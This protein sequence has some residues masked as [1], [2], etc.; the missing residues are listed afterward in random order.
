MSFT[1]VAGR[2]F[3]I[4]HLVKELGEH[5]FR[6]TFLQV[7]RLGSVAA[8]S[9]GGSRGELAAELTTKLLAGYSGSLRPLEAL[10]ADFILAQGSRR[11][12]LHEQCVYLLLAL[13]TLYCG[14]VG[15]APS[16]AKVAFW[17]LAANDYLPSW[18]ADAR[19]LD[20][21]EDAVAEFWRAT[22]FNQ[23]N[24]SKRDLVRGALL[25]RERPP[26]GPLGARWEKLQIEAFGMPYDQYAAELAAP[27]S[28]LA[29]TWGTRLDN[30]PLR[31]P[32]IEPIQWCRGS[33]AHARFFSTRAWTRDEARLRLRESLG[34]SGVPRGIGAFTRRPFMLIGSELLVASP[35][36]VRESLRLSAWASYREAEQKVTGSSG[37]WMPGFGDLLETWCRRIANAGAPRIAAATGAEIIMSRN[38][39]G[40]DEFEDVIITD[41]RRL[42]LFSV[43]SSL[44]PH[45][46]ARTECSKSEVVD[47]HERFFF[48]KPQREKRQRGGVLRQLD[49]K[50]RRVRDGA[51]FPRVARDAFIIPV[52]VTFEH[53]GDSFA[54]YSWLRRRCERERLLYQSTVR[55]PSV[56]TVAEFELLISLAASGAD[57]L[58][59]LGR[60]APEDE[61]V[62]S[63]RLL[64]DLGPRVEFSDL[65]L[66][67]GEFD[68][69]WSRAEERIRQ[70]FAPAQ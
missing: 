55:P 68:S 6:D 8:N 13:A 54:L 56:M 19:A 21:Y 59:R 52:V 60:W 36:P 25:F 34:P 20:T 3:P 9:D 31:S 14:E 23:G 28:L 2:P 40:D 64:R 58:Q 48:E 29:S 37:A 43:K 69:L 51:L 32:I 61:C 11:T 27:L 18:D 62:S 38:I 39:G 45:T 44:A 15:A 65:E 63:E 35:W 50:I 24:H 47:W 22:R 30:S 53:F 7:A 26:R 49:A 70:L 17:L 41:G 4:E 12:V 42:A 57:V 1:E 67:R 10:V 46:I 16:F 33:D 5:N 66:F